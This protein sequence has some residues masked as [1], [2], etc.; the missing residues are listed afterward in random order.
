MLKY[1]RHETVTNGII[2]HGASIKKRKEL[3]GRGRGREGKRKGKM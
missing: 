1:Y 3:K 2:T